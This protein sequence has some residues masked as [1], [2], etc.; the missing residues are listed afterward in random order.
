[1][2]SRQAMP[3]VLS[4]IARAALAVGAL[5]GMM[6]NHEPSL[7][8]IATTLSSI[9]IAG[10][11]LPT[12]YIL[13]LTETPLR[14]PRGAPGPPRRAPVVDRPGFA[15]TSST[16]EIELVNG[17]ILAARVLP[18]SAADG[19][20]EA[21]GF[22]PGGGG[23]CAREDHRGELAAQLGGLVGLGYPI[24]AVAL[25]AVA[26]RLV[27]PREVTVGDDGV[28][29]ERALGATFVPPWSRLMPRSTS[30][31]RRPSRPWSTPE[32]TSCSRRHSVVCRERVC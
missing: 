9:I 4:Q 22:G 17:D 18:P 8:L 30:A 25:H 13:S 26:K 12:S 10:V 28:R 14:P 23:R 6:V 5:A 29:L 19:L 20:V 27:R 15:F 7:S 21:L 32:T 24:L 3:R 1:M 11:L 31:S 2:W 16:V